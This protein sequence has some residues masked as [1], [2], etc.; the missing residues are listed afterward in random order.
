M[1]IDKLKRQERKLRAKL[2]KDL[3]EFLRV[4]DSITKLSIDIAAMHPKSKKIN[5]HVLKAGKHIEGLSKVV[6]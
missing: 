1:K 2:V 6:K 4:A 5:S 3:K